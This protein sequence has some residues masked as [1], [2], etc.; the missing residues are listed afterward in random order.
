MAA[1]R[2]R[3]EVKVF[4]PTAEQKLLNSDPKY[5]AFKVHAVLP[6][7]RI[8]DK[9][10]DA[11]FISKGRKLIIQSAEGWKILYQECVAKLENI[12]DAEGKLLAEVTDRKQIVDLLLHLED[13]EIG[14]ELDNWLLGLS[15]LDE[16][17]EK[18]SD[19]ELAVSP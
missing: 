12:F 2:S 16:E 5:Q 6:D 9:Y 14:R 1:R 8:R 18:N 13:A 10:S 19:G 4:I 3:G 17:E 15:T 11:S 7:K